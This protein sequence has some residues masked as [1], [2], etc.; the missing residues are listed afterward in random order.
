MPANMGEDYSKAYRE[1]F[2]VA[3]KEGNATLI[4]FLLEGVGGIKA[5]NQADGI[6]PNREGH[7]RIA[8]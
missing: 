5:L 2:A 1:I 8:D 7:Q 3:A 4:P 6:H